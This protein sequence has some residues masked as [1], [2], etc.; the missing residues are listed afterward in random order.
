LA[1]PEFVARGRFGKWHGVRAK[2]EYEEDIAAVERAPE[3]RASPAFII[4]AGLARSVAQGALHPGP[5]TV[6]MEV[7]IDLRAE[8]APLGPLGL[9]LSDEVN[10]VLQ[11]HGLT[12]LTSRRVTMLLMPSTAIETTGD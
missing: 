11:D 6:P 1:L 3:L 5:L 10:A 12:S 7:D 9:C 8:R 4:A 2:F